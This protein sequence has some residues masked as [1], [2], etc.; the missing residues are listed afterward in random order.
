MNIQAIKT[1][2]FRENEDLLAFIHHYVPTLSE[3]SVLV[4]TSKI[5]TLAEGRTV[6]FIDADDPA[7]ETLIRQESDWA[8]R[9]KYVWLTLKDGTVMASAGIDRSNAAGKLVL[10]PRDSFASARRICTT[11]KQQYKLKK[12]GV[13][14]TDSRVLPLRAGV[15][16]VATGYAGFRGIRD[17]RGQQDIFGRR[18][19]F[20]R[21]DVADS[22]ASAAVVVMGEGKEQQ[23]LAH[24]TDAPVIFTD[25]SSPRTE[26]RI[27][28]ADDMYQPF[29]ERI[30]NV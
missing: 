23:P 21:T 3:S 11:L 20:S 28:P 13:L 26:L 12:L 17:Y 30:R 6:P 18:L 29:F 15:V 8:M 7:F 25:R 24:I 27:D 9:T 5:V 16:G 2:V 1:R 14:I 4:I 10:L 22:L 19:H